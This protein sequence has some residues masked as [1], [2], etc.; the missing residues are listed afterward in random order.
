MGQCVDLSGE[1]GKVVSEIE[2]GQTILGTASISDHALY[3]RSDGTLW[4]FAAKPDPES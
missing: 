2:L 1:E 3:I 4:K